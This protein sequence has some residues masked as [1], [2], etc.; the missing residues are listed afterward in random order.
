AAV[1]T[2]TLRLPDA[3]PISAAA[4]AAARTRVATEDEAHRGNL[5]W[6]DP[7]GGRRCRRRMVFRCRGGTGLRR[8]PAE[9]ALPDFHDR[10][11]HRL[12]RKSTRLNS[13]HAKISY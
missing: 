7:R 1:R 5:P 8:R 12:D 3:L 9:C 4:D 13:S 11:D 6:S 10:R 2:Y